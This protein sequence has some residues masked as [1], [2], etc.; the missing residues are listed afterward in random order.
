MV[1]REDMAETLRYN[2]RLTELIT[3]R[4]RSPLEPL[5]RQL[6]EVDWT[7]RLDLHGSLRSLRLRHQVGGHWHGYPKHRWR[8]SLLI[9]SGGR[10]GGTLEP[11]AERYFAAAVGLDV[12]P[13]GGPPE[14]F[15][16]REEEQRVD[17]WLDQR[18][19]GRERALVALA[20]GAAH[21]TKRWPSSHWEALVRRLR[22]RYDLVVVGGRAEQEVAAAMVAAGGERT[23]SAAG[24]FTLTDTAVALRRARTLVAG[25][26][27]VLHLATA[28]GTPAVALY[29][30]T[31][32]A[33]GFFPYQARA[34]V[35]ERPLDCRPCSAHGGQRCPLG[36]HRC[37]V[38]I[39]P[40]EV[41]AAV[42]ALPR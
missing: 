26:T 40:E 37:L 1:V 35:L 6:R 34:T 33:F 18:G 22:G 31:V 15:T 25:D 14:F 41:A 11:I 3:W 7:H 10:L 16:S 38:D 8:R 32:A 42:Q 2:P 23:A 21:F 29:G 30:P 19:L 20:P 24:E 36:H 5:V 12:I 9:R 27:G 28:V 17:A 13:D 4:H 39:A